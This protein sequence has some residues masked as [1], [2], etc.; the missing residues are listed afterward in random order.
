MACVR[1]QL[2][3][4]RVSLFLDVHPDLRLGLDGYASGFG[5]GNASAMIR[6]DA[7]RTSGADTFRSVTDPLK[8]LKELDLL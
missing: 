6:T 4:K 7:Q 8:R 2:I 1:Q 5:K 3:A